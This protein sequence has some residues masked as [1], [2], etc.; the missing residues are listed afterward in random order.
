MRLFVTGLRGL[1]NVMGGVE[2]HCEEL[3]PRIKALRPDWDITVLARA[4]YVSTPVATHKGVR[5]RAL[6]APKRASIEAIV[7]T[8]IGVL[9]AFVRRADL[10]HIHAIGPGLMSPVARLLGLRVVVTCHGR[11]HQRVKWGGIAR[12][13]LRLGERLS[14]TFANKVIVV[15]PSVARDLAAAYPRHAH[16]LV[17]IP[18]GMP[19]LAVGAEEPIEIDG[20]EPGYVLTVGR[21]DPGKGLDYLIDGVLAADGAMKLL[22]VG[23]ADHENDYSRKLMSRASDRVIFAGRQPRAALKGLYE[24][25]GIFVLPSFHEGLPISA[26][27]AASLGTP[28]LLS[29]I[30]ANKAIGLPEHHYFP[31][32]NAEALAERLR[33]PHRAFEVDPAPIRERF[34][35]ERIAKDTEAVY[36][37]VCG[38]Q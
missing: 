15:S 5:V 6:P 37:E 26:L 12:R 36:G 8:A 18:N 2:S 21:I 32:G 25:A 1:P 30:E 23:G 27:E 35:W 19:D 13:M 28:T 9:Y 7:A 33:Q 34:D 17:Y 11:D 38:R 16:K 14:V 24:R 31:V 20:A 29:D 10:L 4:P 22:I 3:L